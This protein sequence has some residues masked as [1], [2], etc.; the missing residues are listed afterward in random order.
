M[1]DPLA[2]AVSQHLQRILHSTRSHDSLSRDLLRVAANYRLEV[3]RPRIQ[4]MLGNVVAGGLFAGMR[5]LPRASEGC[6]VPKLLGCYEAGLQ[7]HLGRFIDDPP[8]VILNIGCAEGWYAVGCAR[9]LPT[10]EI[11]AFDINPAA[12]ALCAEMAGLNGV[13]DRIRVDGEFS[14]RDFGPFAGRRV[15]VLCDIEGAEHALLDPEAA[16][17]LRGFDLIVE[18]HDGAV[19]IS[20]ILKDR[21]TPTHEVIEVDA[22]IDGF[23]PPAWLAAQP[24]IDQLLA[25]W[26]MRRAPTPWLVM[27]ALGQAR[28]RD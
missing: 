18:A 14:A 7:H 12:Q 19:P 25:I 16:P 21:F 23:R 9:L 26:E 2:T 22:G 3:L 6:V 4:A 20:R 8:E 5:L 15:L 13:R 1:S 28:I 10:A 17:A 11:H 24:E 27:R